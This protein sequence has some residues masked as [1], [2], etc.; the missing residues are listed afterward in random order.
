MTGSQYREYTKKLIEDEIE[1]RKQAIE[2][3]ADFVSNPDYKAW[4]NRHKKAKQKAEDALNVWEVSH[5][6]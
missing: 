3:T 5:G 2:T 1:Y 4:E 6:D